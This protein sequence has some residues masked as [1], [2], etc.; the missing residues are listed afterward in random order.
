MNPA[1]LLLRLASVRECLETVCASG[2]DR[3]VGRRALLLAYCL[4]PELIGTQRALAKRMG[5]TEARVSQM[6]KVLRRGYR[7][8]SAFALTHA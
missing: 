7:K 6:L 4:D 1:L 5:V 3:A 8:N 2:D